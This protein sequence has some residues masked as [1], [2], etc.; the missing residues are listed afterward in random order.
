MAYFKISLTSTS[1]SG[2]AA[3]RGRRRNCARYS[4]NCTRA[5]RAAASSCRLSRSSAPMRSPNCW[6]TA[7]C[8][9]SPKMASFNS[10]NRRTVCWMRSSS[11]RKELTS[12]D[13]SASSSSNWRTWLNTGK[14]SSASV[15]GV[16]ACAGLS[17]DGTYGVDGA[18]V[19]A[20][21]LNRCD[22]ATLDTGTS[23]NPA[24]FFWG[25]ITARLRLAFFRCLCARSSA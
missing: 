5:P 18:G 3:A 4:I 9:I 22:D 7:N 17:D 19:P 8:R 21:G 16:G 2:C 23:N 6:C 11:S 13:K 20:K 24:S 14:P 12:R 15:V 25:S 10:I 1:G